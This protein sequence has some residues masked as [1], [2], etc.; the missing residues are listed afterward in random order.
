MHPSDYANNVATESKS[1]TQQQQQQQ[2]QLANNSTIATQTGRTGEEEE[3]A[4][5]TD[6]D[7]FDN[8]KLS[9]DQHCYE[10]K[11]KYRDPRPK[12]L[13]MFLHAWKYS[14]CTQKYTHTYFFPNTT[15]DLI[16][17]RLK[18]SIFFIILL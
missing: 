13:I 1:V 5:V 16:Q 12:D 17:M 14:V 7:R 2:Q 15:N 10:C 9:T 6:D 4:A 18:M 11:V 3:A 8:A